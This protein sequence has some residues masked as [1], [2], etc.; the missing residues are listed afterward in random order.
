MGNTVRHEAPKRQTGTGFV[1]FI[2]RFAVAAIVLW[3]TSYLLAGF[4]IRGGIVPLLIAALVI[5]A[6]DYLVEK[7]FKI[8]ASPFGNGLKGFLVSVVII[9]FAQYFVPGMEVSLMGAIVG[10]LVIGLIDAIL[11]TRVM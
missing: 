9:Y 11:P 2:I 8:D 5:S 3:V 10:A 7:L 4:N 1:G 6:A